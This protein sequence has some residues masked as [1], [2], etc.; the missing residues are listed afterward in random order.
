MR[1]SVDYRF[2]HLQEGPA[3]FTVFLCSDAANILQNEDFRAL[4][5]D[6]V[7][8]V[9]EDFAPWIVRSFLL[10]HTAERLTWKATCI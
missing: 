3:Y 1:V 10:S 5:I 7:M 8:N 4:G 9:I 6:V 2:E